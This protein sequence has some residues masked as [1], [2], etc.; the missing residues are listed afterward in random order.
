[1]EHY[2][3]IYARMCQTE[4]KLATEVAAWL[5]R[6]EAADVAKD[7]EHGPVQRGDDAAA[8][9]HRAATRFANPRQLMA[10]LGLVPSEHCSGGTRRQGGITMAATARRG[11][12]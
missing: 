1:M 12:C 3:E 6:A 2:A 7:A 11:G 4:D 9:A 5:E 10:Y 8:T